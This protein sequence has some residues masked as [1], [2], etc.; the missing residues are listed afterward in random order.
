[1][2]PQGTALDLLQGIYSGC[3]E[4]GD[5]SCVKPKVLAFISTAVKQDKI[6]ISKD[7]SVV[8][9]SDVPTEEILQVE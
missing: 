9:R 4:E 8:R 6:R 2:V 1:M 3:V 5:F 7:L